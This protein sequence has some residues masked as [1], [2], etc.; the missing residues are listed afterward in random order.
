[1]TFDNHNWLDCFLWWPFCW[2]RL[3]AGNLFL[4]GKKKKC[5]PNMPAV[6]AG[7]SSILGLVV[8]MIL[9]DQIWGRSDLTTSV[10][11]CSRRSVIPSSCDFHWSFTLCKFMKNTHFSLKTSAPSSTVTFEK[12][13]K[14]QLLTAEVYGSSYQGKDIFSIKVAKKTFDTSKLVGGCFV[15]IITLDFGCCSI[16]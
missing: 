6:L 3:V 2:W 4:L 10:F 12:K 15:H 5:L 13:K 16:L 11:V 14:K 1:M 9:Y 8:L 7:S